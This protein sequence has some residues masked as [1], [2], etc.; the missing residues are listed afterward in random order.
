MRIEERLSRAL[1][2]EA[3]GREVDLQRLFAATRDRVD[4]TPAP[5]RR[6]WA[7]AL[8][9]AATAAVV[10]AGALLLPG[11]DLSLLPAGP[12]PSGGPVEGG[13]DDAFTCPEQVT[14]DW[15]RPETITDDYFVASLDGGPRAQARNHDAA[16]YE[17]E[18]RGDRAYLRFGN[19]DGT[20]ATVSEFRRNGD[21]WVRFRT[22]VC[23]G[24]DGSVA[25]PTPDEDRLGRHDGEPYPPSTLGGDR[26][27]A[28]VLVDD[29]SYYDGV[30]LVR[31]RSIYAEP[32]GL[33]V[34][35]WAIQDPTSLVAT[36]TRAGDAGRP[37]DMSGLFWPP[38]ETVGRP[39]DDGLW[40][41]YDTEG[42]ISDLSLD[43]R[44]GRII[45]ADKLG[46]ESW[47]G[48]VYVLL[49]PFDQVEALTVHRAAGSEPG[50]GGAR[51]FV[52][53]NL[54][55]YDPRG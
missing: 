49:A 21:E 50:A 22:D 30:G 33:Q 15:T 3:D 40:V 19:A 1:H 52:P 2:E 51:N 10:A 48:T 16:R 55:G 38:D 29:R 13:V 12:D 18:E 25:V 43:L 45:W 39:Q 53:E 41:L 46:K 9:A 23:T 31:H 24:R 27:N 17:Y 44:D 20:L 36:Q 6:P 5:P 26:S 35:V 8:A 32:C 42:M 34:C 28:A 47:P 11:A 14:H 7:V 4:A 37:R 54:P